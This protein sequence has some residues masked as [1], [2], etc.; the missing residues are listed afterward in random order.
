MKYYE[1][2]FSFSIR[3]NNENMLF[4]VPVRYNA[5]ATKV[6]KLFSCLHQVSMKCRMLINIKIVRIKGIF[7]LK[8]QLYIL[9]INVKIRT[10][11]EVYEQDKNHAWLS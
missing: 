8:S 6:M 9:L 4:K 10:T 3:L 11:V 1:K 2:D 7:V 5:W